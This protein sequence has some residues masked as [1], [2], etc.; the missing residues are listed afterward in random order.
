[1][2]LRDSGTTRPEV[3]TTQILKHFLTRLPNETRVALGLS[4]QEIQIAK[5]V[6]GCIKESQ[7]YEI[8]S[9]GGGIRKELKVARDIVLASATGEWRNTVVT[10]TCNAHMCD[11]GPKLAEF[12]LVSPAAVFLGVTYQRLLT[13]IKKN[14]NT[15]TAVNASFFSPYREHVWSF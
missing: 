14:T 10:V 11:L 9:L 1:M 3:Q 15:L 12:K 6:C 7:A 2:C 4:V 5:I 13:A 8:N